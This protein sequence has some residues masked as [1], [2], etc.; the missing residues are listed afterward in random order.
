MPAMTL[1]SGP[2]QLAQRVPEGALAVEQVC[3]R[4]VLRI[5]STRHE[6]APE[7][8]RQQRKRDPHQATDITH[9][10]APIVV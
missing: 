5:G 10:N 4:F 6:Q 3:R 7:G 2:W 1:P 9:V 8:N